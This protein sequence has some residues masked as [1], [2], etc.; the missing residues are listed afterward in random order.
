MVVKVLVR[1]AESSLDKPLLVTTIV[2]KTGPEEF[3]FSGLE[4]AGWGRVYVTKWIPPPLILRS[5]EAIS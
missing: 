4:I 2:F 5:Y 1:A 3:S